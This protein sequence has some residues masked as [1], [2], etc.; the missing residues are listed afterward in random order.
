VYECSGP[1][2]LKGRVYLPL[3]EAWRRS[4]GRMV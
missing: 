1:A 3:R 4:L 2:S